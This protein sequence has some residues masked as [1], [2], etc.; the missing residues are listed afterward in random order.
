MITKEL[1]YQKAFEIKNETLKQKIAKREMLLGAAYATN[2][3]LKEIDN[4]LAFIGA[5]LAITALAGNNEKIAVLKK[6]SVALSKEKSAIL[7][8]EMVTDI[9]YDCTICND[10][11]YVGG[12]VCECVKKIAAQVV[13]DELAKQMPLSESSFENFDLGYYSN[14]G[15][16]PRKRMNAIF[17]LC[18]EYANN[19]NPETAQNLLFMG[20]PGLGKTHLTLAIVASVVDKGFMPFYGPA[21][22]LFTLAST[23]RF[24]GENK[25]SYQ[26]MLESDLLVIDD[27]G[28]EL[29][30]EF[31]RSVLYNLING[32]LLS[33]KPTIINT[34]LTMKE[35]ADRY[36]DR[37]ASRLIGNYNANKFIGADIRQQKFL[38]ENRGI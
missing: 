27:L 9:K 8:K 1:T 22:N 25:G 38:K 21:E 5:Q 17:K 29:S 37:I 35:I 19:F 36:G 16:N 7:K 26:A 18:K 11:G 13:L 34:N 3:R 23:E 12:K 2:P 31:S 32:R 10:S 24:T 6:N 30:T 15:E 14:D 33:K 20:A 28:T 4:E